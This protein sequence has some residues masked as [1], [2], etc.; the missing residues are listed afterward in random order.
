VLVLLDLLLLVE[1]RFVLELG[2]NLIYLV[3]KII[4]LLQE[5]ILL[6]KIERN[7]FLEHFLEV[8]SL[9][10]LHF[11]PRRSIFH[12]T[13]SFLKRILLLHSVRNTLQQGA[14]NYLAEH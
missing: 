11:K 14:L 2:D 8:Q 12:V 1:F 7:F 4:G 5:R 9:L 3:L 13:L 6:F 10:L